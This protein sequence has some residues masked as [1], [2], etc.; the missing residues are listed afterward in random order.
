MGTQLVCGNVV[1]LVAYALVLWRFFDRRIEGEEEL[2]VAFFGEEYVQ[3]RKRT[4]VGIPGI[5]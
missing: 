2:L 4:W 3:Y 1:C 5:K